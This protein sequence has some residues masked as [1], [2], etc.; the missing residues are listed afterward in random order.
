MPSTTSLSS[1]CLATDMSYLVVVEG[2]EREFQAL[3]TVHA[4]RREELHHLLL[5]QH[6]ARVQRCNIRT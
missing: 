1:K 6:V 5:H 3:R 2:I 4:E